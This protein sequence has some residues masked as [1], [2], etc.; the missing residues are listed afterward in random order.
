MM[1]WSL[2]QLSGA[3]HLIRIQS[4]KKLVWWNQPQ[5]FLSS[6]EQNVD[7]TQL[8]NCQQFTR[9]LSV[10]V[11]PLPNQCE[12][13]PICFSFVCA[14]SE[15][16]LN[17]FPCWHEGLVLFQCSA[18]KSPL[19]GVTFKQVNT[20]YRISVWNFLD[21]R[22]ILIFELLHQVFIAFR[23]CFVSFKDLKYLRITVHFIT[24]NW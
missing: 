19:N 8:G 9:G 15:T 17:H 14:V 16:S 12:D 11:F 24:I 1:K 22:V 23:R 4:V 13:L 5:I 20:F 6:N 18:L 10:R 21:T 7:N 3:P 2:S